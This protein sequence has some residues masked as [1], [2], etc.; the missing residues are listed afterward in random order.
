MAKPLIVAPKFRP[1]PRITNGEDGI[2]HYIVAQR[3]EANE[4][5]P[6]EGMHLVV[7]CDRKLIAGVVE[8]DRKRG[9][10]RS[11][12]YVDRPDGGK[13]LVKDDE[14]TQM[15]RMQFG[16]ITYRLLPL[17]RRMAESTPGSRVRPVALERGQLGAAALVIASAFDLPPR[18]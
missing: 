10:V 18:R 17:P 12:H 14:G 2:P 3:G 8:A 4:Y 5:T 6:P 15:Y 7:F 11:L 13:T 9:F 1:P 16:K